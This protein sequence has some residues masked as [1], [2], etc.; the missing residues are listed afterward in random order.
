M[1]QQPYLFLVSVIVTVAV[2]L[3]NAAA[4]DGVHASDNDDSADCA[5]FSSSRYFNLRLMFS[6]S[7]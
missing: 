5:S 4:A 1:G 7:T 6:N 2:I 3:N